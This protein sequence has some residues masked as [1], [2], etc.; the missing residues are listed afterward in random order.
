MNKNSFKDK[1]PCKEDAKDHKLSFSKLN[2]NFL[3]WNHM[4][5]DQVFAHVLFCW[6]VI[7]NAYKS[8]WIPSMIMKLTHGL[9]FRL[10]NQSFRI[11][12]FQD[13][14]KFHMSPA[15]TFKD[16]IGW[17]SLCTPIDFTNN[18]KECEL[19]M[20][21]LIG[22]N[23]E[24]EGKQ[25][26]HKLLSNNANRQIRKTIK[27]KRKEMHGKIL[28]AT[29][30]NDKVRKKSDPSKWTSRKSTKGV[31]DPEKMMHFTSL[32]EKKMEYLL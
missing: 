16:A 24:K 14:L 17:R 5:H 1:N 4:T 29:S 10:T 30:K 25:G 28:S 19:K 22:M 13:L 27:I 7:A 26:F 18:H 12:I 32:D 9:R 6:D 2:H 11:I 21:C 3:E 23:Y 20:K 15:G 31:F 8:H